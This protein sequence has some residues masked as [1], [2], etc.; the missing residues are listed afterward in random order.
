M[1]LSPT[2]LAILGSILLFGFLLRR[3]PA[4]VE[5]NPHYRELLW[6]NGLDDVGDFLDREAVIISGHP[7]RHVARLTL[8]AANFYLKREERVPWTVRLGN[9]FAGFGF[10]SL[11]LREASVLRALPRAGIDGPDWVASGEDRRGR[12]FLLLHEVPGAVEL[13]ILLAE[14]GDLRSRVEL[15]RALGLA[16]AKVHEAAFDH[17]DLYAKHVLV[18]PNSLEIVF[19]DWQRSRL[20]RVVALDTRA[21][22]LA[23]LNV[24]I[25]AEL[26][27][28]GARLACLRAY[29]AFWECTREETRALARAIL[30]RSARLLCRRHVREKLRA[31]ATGQQWIPHEGGTVCVTPA[32]QR[33]QP[34]R[35]AWLSLDANPPEAGEALTCRE[36]SL[37]AGRDAVLVRRRA[38][39]FVRS[40]W[41]TFR[42]RP[43]PSPEE[44]QAALLLRLERY[45]VLAPR[46]LAMGCRRGRF[47]RVD[48]LLLTEAVVGDEAL[49]DWV[50]RAWDDTNRRRVLSDVGRLLRR[51]HEACC[52]LPDRD[53][54][55]TLRR[56]D[57]GILLPVLTGADDLLVTRAP[58]PSLVGRNLTAVEREFRACGATAS[59]L[60]WLLEGYTLAETPLP[61]IALEDQ[62]M[63]ADR[64]PIFAHATGWVD[65]AVAAA[66][67]VATMPVAVVARPAAR[68]P[69]PRVSLWS[70]L[71]RGNR[72][73]S[74]RAD[75]AEFAGD[76]WADRIMGVEI[77]DRFH[78]KQ[79]RS[80]CRWILHRPGTE[81][82][83]R[84]LSVYLKRHYRLSWWRGLLAA[85]WPGGNWSPA[86]E[87]LEHL[88]WAR[89]Q[90]VPVP[91]VVAAAEYIGPW[92]RFQSVL[93][94]EELAG[95]LPLHEAVPLAA[96]RLDPQTF[97]TWKRGLIVEMARLTRLL[98][99]KR[100][101]HKDLYLCH[102]YI[103]RDDTA[104]VPEW[105]GKV[106]LIDLHRLT[107]HPWTWRVWQTKDLAQLLYSSEVPGIDA[108]DRLL[109]W[110]EYRGPDGRG[111]G[112]WIRPYVLFRWRRYR[113][114]NARRK[115]AVAPDP[116]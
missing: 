74:E 23:A 93:A 52:H 18:D 92:G 43:T 51:L 81:G 114:H 17:P 5:V 91:E 2:F 26:A 83:E 36:V 65:P 19:L 112:A 106:F 11:S 55:L 79:G 75:W 78:A 95:M 97:R 1:L 31:P 34:T 25:P 98:H 94:V 101:Y 13:R 104:R 45:G 20:R 30:A 108:G 103:A 12:A 67:G 63:P 100:H 50:A 42:L 64:Q 59:D 80:T 4:F 110:R 47:G 3:R 48:S 72:R 89:S 105:R 68:A 9:A 66:E 38:R 58:S 84:R 102:F 86:F 77:S 116:I 73:L 111:A 70:R 7:N 28:R 54:P 115:A 32:F 15:A 60:R 35:P 16:V 90:G 33:L 76:D 113:R 88:E 24:T 69:A 41:D 14:K 61:A 53:F 109:F 27:T 46:V 87:E 85:L 8:G 44:R 29:A 21:R 37:G 49:A 96:T 99:D 57:D 107:H 39:S 82:S 62:Q 22:D 40:L 56:S 10:V 6:E 71:F